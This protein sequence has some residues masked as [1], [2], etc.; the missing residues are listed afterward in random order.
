MLRTE[1]C[2]HYHLGFTGE[3]EE[4]KGKRRD[5]ATGVGGQAQAGWGGGDDT[6][7]FLMWTVL[8]VVPTGFIAGLDAV[9]GENSRITPRLG[10]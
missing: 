8:Q 3:R 6:I 1:A 10:T 2:P 4:Q 9:E 7:R 5:R